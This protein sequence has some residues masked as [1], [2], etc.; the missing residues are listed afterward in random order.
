MRIPENMALHITASPG[1]E[2]T[3]GHLWSNLLFQPGSTLESD[4]LIQ[5]LHNR[6][7]RKWDRY[8]AVR[9]QFNFL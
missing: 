9:T 4:L 7:A 6:V 8:P 1:L 2:G 5:L 3:A